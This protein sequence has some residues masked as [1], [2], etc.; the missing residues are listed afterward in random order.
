VVE[1][2]GIVPAFA[3]QIALAPDDG[4]ALV[5]LTNGTKNGGFWLP[6]ETD[7]LLRH[8][9]GVAD[10][11]IRTDVPQ[12]PETW[13]D[14]CGWYSLPG[15][16]TDLRARGFIGAGVEVF[17]RG[18]RLHWRCLSPVPALYKGMPLHP[19][20]P[21]D[22]WVFRTELPGLDVTQQIVFSRHPGT[23]STAVHFGLMPLS[24][25]RQPTATNPRRW[26]SGAVAAGSAAFVVRR[27][28]R[29]AVGVR[30]AR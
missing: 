16:V 11:G 2:Q 27:R 3:S 8:L 30:P 14:L 22:P 1:H 26:A 13:A 15:P 20:H 10:E 25:C 23:G 17:V 6:L 12:H 21:E 18:G 7:R 29:R 19:D 5:A 4:L 24:A 9:L 28:R